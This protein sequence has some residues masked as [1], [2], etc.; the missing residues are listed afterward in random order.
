M[1]VRDTGPLQLVRVFADLTA[2]PINARDT[3]YL[4]TAP[5]R[6]VAAEV[7]RAQAQGIRDHDGW[8]VGAILVP[9]SASLEAACRM[10]W[11]GGSRPPGTIVEM[12]P[13]ERTVTA[14]TQGAA[15]S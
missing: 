12:E 7:A 3:L 1:G 10:P 14:G 5:A 15:P 9:H 13:G 2:S 8:E 6:L 11:C 4:D